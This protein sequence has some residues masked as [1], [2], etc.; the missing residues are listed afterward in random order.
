[1]GQMSE[2]SWTLRLFLKTYRWRRIDPVPWAPLK[3]PLSQCR[4]AL[5]SSAGFVMPDQEPFDQSFKGGDPSFREIPDKADVRTLVEAHRSEAFD[6]SGLRQDLNLAFP[7]DRVHELVAAGRIGATNRRHLSCMGSITAPGRLTRE[8]A[9][10]AV[11]LL[12]EDGV[13][14]ALLVPV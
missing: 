6:H 4:L 8:T 12:V 13:D 1:M 3:K 9:P 10:A 7:L 5:V 11:R 2:F 14:V